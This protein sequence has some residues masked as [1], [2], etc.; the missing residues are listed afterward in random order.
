MSVEQIPPSGP[1][2]SEVPET[3][4][5]FVETGVCYKRNLFVTNLWENKRNFVILGFS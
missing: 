3:R 5:V 4:K 2:I 1:P